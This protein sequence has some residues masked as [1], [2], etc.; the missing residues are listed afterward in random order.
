[1]LPHGAGN[2]QRKESRKPILETIRPL[3]QPLSRKNGWSERRQI[4]DQMP[5]YT[6][7]PLKA[8]YESERMSLGVVKPTSIVRPHLLVPFAV[9]CITLTDSSNAATS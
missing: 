6:V 8:L 1:M 3:G 4:I 2:D 9:W 5:V 7:K